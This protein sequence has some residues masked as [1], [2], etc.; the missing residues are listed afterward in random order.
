MSSKKLT[1]KKTK[2]AIA[3]YIECGNYSE[4]ARK[5]KVS[6]NTIKKWVKEQPDIA[7]KC[8]QKKE[9]NAQ[10]MLQYINSKK[11]T[12]MEFID[13]ALKG[14]MNE[15]KIQ[16]APVQQLATSIAIIIDKFSVTA[17]ND[18]KLSKVD[19]LLQEIKENAKRQTK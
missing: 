17:D 9:E 15:E 19:M 11:V 14:M 7:E 18:T 10:D 13:I 16:K 4:V 5:Y 3:D 8:E 6:P 2:Q 1:D 12:A